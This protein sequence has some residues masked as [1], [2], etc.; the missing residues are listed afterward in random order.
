MSSTQ[1]L[2]WVVL[3]YVAFAVFVV[4]H[5]WR[6]R[7]DQFGWTT[8][9]SQIYESRLL[10][11]GSP[12][13]HLGILM[14]LGGHVI[15][16]VVPAS[17]TSAVGISEHVYHVT[18]VSA[19][20]VAGLM[21]LV[22]LVLLV[23]RRRSVRRVFRATTRTDKL[24]YVVLGAVV[25]L[26]VA[27]TIHGNLLGGPYD[28][29]ESVAVWFRGVFWLHPRGELMAATPFTFQ[30][31]AVVAMLLFALWPFT[32]LV[33]VLSVPLG[34]LGRPYIVYRSRDL[35]QRSSREERRGWEKIGS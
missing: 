2:L 18:A 30:A 21:T 31:H 24:L 9:S 8:R 5:V 6:Y 15:G 23:V 14:A 1:T 32:R 25:V 10:R 4:G 16:L 19:G 20:T 3:P 34:Y 12:L 13:F 7:Y 29:R 27:N 33:H 35:T 22:G 11:L 28:Y 17:W 26:G